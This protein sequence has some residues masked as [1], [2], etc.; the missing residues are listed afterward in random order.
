MRLAQRER[1]DAEGPRR[2]DIRNRNYGSVIK[3][4]KQQSVQATGKH[5]SK[6]EGTVRENKHENVGDSGGHNRFPRGHTPPLPSVEICIHCGEE[7]SGK[8]IM[9]RSGMSQVVCC[10]ECWCIHE[11]EEGGK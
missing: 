5:E 2:E 3:G 8:D 9:Y 10:D 4:A 7:L 11:F 1:Q 6:S